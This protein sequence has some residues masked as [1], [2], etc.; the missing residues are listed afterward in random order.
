MKTNSRDRMKH[1]EVS[2]KNHGIVISFTC[3]H[4]N[5]GFKST[6]SNY[7]NSTIPSD[8]LRIQK[9][10]A[11]RRGEKLTYRMHYGFITRVRS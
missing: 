1:C 2:T 3:H 10:E 6:I 8:G 9:N 7:N 4:L 5:S 11:F